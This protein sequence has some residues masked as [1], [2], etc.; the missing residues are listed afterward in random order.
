MRKRFIA[1]HTYISEE[2]KKKVLAAPFEEDKITDIE[3]AKLWEFKK[4]SCIAAWQGNEDFFFCHWEADT[5]EDIHEALEEN[6][7]NKLCVT[8]CYRIHFHAD[9]NKLTGQIRSYPPWKD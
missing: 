2:H 3:W 9:R 7:L 5:E 8:A 6:G 4:C 1:I